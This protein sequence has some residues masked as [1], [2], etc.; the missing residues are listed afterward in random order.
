M[1]NTSSPIPLY[2]QVVEIFTDHIQSGKYKEGDVLPSETSLA[3]HYKIGR[4]T[5]RQAMDVLVQKGMIERKRGSGT[6]VKKMESQVD[7]FSLA[8][9]SAAFSTKGVEV[10]TQ[11]ITE[12]ITKKVSQDIEN[13]FSEKEAFHLS[14]LTFA[15]KKPILLEEIFLNR[16]LFI[17]IDKLDIKGKSLARI[18]A[19]KYF[20]KPE[21]AI[22]RFKIAYLPPKKASLLHLISSDP[23]LEV[24]RE[25][26]FPDAPAAV[27][28]ILYCRTDRF[29]FSQIISG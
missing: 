19:D 28:A 29:V 25:I 7:L 15:R 20:L 24:R 26:N 10:E 18:V 13:P 1:L 17:G 23:V 9:T 14:R 12:V 2:Q 4:P 22:Q 6:F 8:G 16:E 5:V 11:I 3:D 27:Y 21:N